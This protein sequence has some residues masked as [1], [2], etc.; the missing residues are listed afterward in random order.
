[1]E[2]HTPIENPIELTKRE[3]RHLRRMSPEGQQGDSKGRLWRV[4]GVT[5]VIIVALAGVISFAKSAKTPMTTGTLVDSTVGPLDHVKGNKMASTT[6]I[7]YSDFQCPAC[8]AYYPVVKRIT[9]TYG[10]DLAIVYRHFPLTQHKNAPLAARVAE[11]A[12]KQGKFW[13][14][15][16]LLFTNQNDWAELADPMA[17]FTKYATSLSLNLTTFK[18]DLDDAALLKKIN[19]DQASGLAA[20][21]SYTPS[22]YLNGK[23]LNVN[24]DVE[25]TNAVAKALGR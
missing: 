20:G 12:G 25:L 8:G 18:R 17:V 14:M 16:D 2:E 9:E 11:A 15:H 19:D 7:E 21:V 24:G 13:E 10:K 4:L 5:L 22:F 6:L 1:M 23:L 3:R